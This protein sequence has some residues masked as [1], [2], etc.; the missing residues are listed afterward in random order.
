M[1]CLRYG[2][3]ISFAMARPV[4]AQYTGSSAYGPTGVQ[5]PSLSGQ[6]APTNIPQGEM[7]LPQVNVPASA[8]NQFERN[9]ILSIPR[10]PAANGRPPMKSPRKT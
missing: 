9:P 6:G 10:S 3:D 2:F 4:A 7:A 1:P 5:A 8:E